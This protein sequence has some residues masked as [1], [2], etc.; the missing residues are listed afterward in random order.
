MRQGKAG[1]TNEEFDQSIEAIRK[2]LITPREERVIAAAVFIMRELRNLPDDEG[3]QPTHPQ[4]LEF[5]NSL[6][7][8]L[9][10]LLK[11]VA[12]DVAPERRTLH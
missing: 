11:R 8:Q 2:G 5:I 3:W 7:K 12:D 4:I 10:R 9:R 1:M 6:D